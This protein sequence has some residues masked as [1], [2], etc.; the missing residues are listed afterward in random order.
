MNEEEKKDVPELDE[1]EE[2]LST[3]TNKNK[4]IWLFLLILDVVLLCVFG[5]FLYKN[6][7]AHLL[8]APLVDKPALQ[9]LEVEEVVVNITE[10]AKEVVAVPAPAVVAETKPEVKSAEKPVEQEAQ[11]P[12]AQPKETKPT[13]EK[14]AAEKPAATVA[15]PKPETKPEVKPAP[16]KKAEHKDSVIVKVTPNSKYRQVTFR[17]FG[18]AKEVAVVSGFTMAK[19]RAL[20]KK[21]GVWE[22]TLGI[23]PGTY[24]YLF[25]VD[26]EQV[27]DPYAEEKGGRS[28]LVVK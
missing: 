25:V 12:A 14:P 16:A 13:A 24:R 9:P 7:S 11:K 4:D 10:P 1:F 19:P 28:V 17:Y 23:E 22:V 21:N 18:T 3:K 8:S 20:T 2:T 5:F 27:V 26:G 6:L 15:A